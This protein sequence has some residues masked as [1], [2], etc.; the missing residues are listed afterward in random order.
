[1]RKCECISCA[2]RT[3]RINFNGINYW[4][5]ENLY[6]NHLFTHS[7]A[8]ERSR[9]RYA[10]HSNYI[11]V[12]EGEWRESK[13]REK[14]RLSTAPTLSST[15]STHAWAPPSSR[16]ASA[17]ICQS[18]LLLSPRSPLLCPHHLLR[19]LGARVSGQLLLWERKWEQRERAPARTRTPRDTW[20]RPTKKC[21]RI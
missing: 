3:R 17:L 15:A 8:S 20:H 7:S 2:K 14:E 21:I 10:L 11:Y 18:M 19:L 5:D 12:R 6:R 1:M 9:V 4:R 13:R 16:N